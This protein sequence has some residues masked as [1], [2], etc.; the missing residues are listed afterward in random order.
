ELKKQF[1]DMIEFELKVEETG[2]IRVPD[3]QYEKWRRTANEEKQRREHLK[4][5]S[6]LQ[7]SA[8]E[9]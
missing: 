3:E 7:E 1:D 9:K 2:H 8:N 4:L 5:M 6:K